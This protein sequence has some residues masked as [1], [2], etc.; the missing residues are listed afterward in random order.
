MNNDYT[1]FENQ[2]YQAPTQTQQQQV[3]PPQQ[4][5]QNQQYGG[6][7]QQQ[8][9]YQQ[10]S[11]GVQADDDDLDM[12]GTIE[13]DGQDF[14][15]LPAGTYSFV[16]VDFEQSKYQE[17]P[18]A[19]GMPG[20]V[21]NRM[22]VS[23]Q[24]EHEGQKHT[25]KDF[26]ALKKNMEWKFCQLFK[27]IGDRKKG[28]RL[29]MDWDNIRGKGGKVKIKVESFLG[30]NG[31][32]KQSNK[33]DRY[34]DPAEAAPQQAAPQQ[35][36]VQQPTFQQPQQQQQAPLVNGNVPNPTGQAGNWGNGGFQ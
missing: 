22:I 21:R 2:Q 1:Q 13:D 34:L 10:Q 8:Q 27:G 24:V 3:T 7:P 29:V 18:K 6:A 16:V 15:L 35:T 12:N 5:N 32:T 14:V 23:I 11:Q 25:L 30:K 9:G 19:Q 4:Y 20:R 26:L 31:A 33:I 28:E 17:K 36:Q